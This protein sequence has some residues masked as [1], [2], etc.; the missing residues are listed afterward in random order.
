VQCKA[1]LVHPY[2]HNTTAGN[3]KSHLSSSA[4]QKLSIRKQLPKGKIQNLLE[5]SLKFFIS[6]SK[7]LFQ[8]VA[9]N[10][11]GDSMFVILFV[12]LSMYLSKQICC[13][14]FDSEYNILAVR[15]FIRYFE[16]VP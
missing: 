10:H 12:I 15:Y 16:Y 13:L 2:N 9:N 7:R 4:C 11:T 6:H 5:V 8:N 3:L 1:E 14:A